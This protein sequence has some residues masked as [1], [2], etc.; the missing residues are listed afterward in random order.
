P[1]VKLSATPLAGGTVQIVNWPGRYGREKLINSA[2]RKRR[3]DGTFDLTW[4]QGSVNVS[5]TMRIISTSQPSGGGGDQP[6]QQSLRGLQLPSSVAD[7]SAGAAQ[8]A[9]QTTG[10]G[11]PAAAPAVAAAN[12]T[13]AQ[14]AQ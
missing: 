2:Q 14:G 7:A 1:G 6:Q 11:T 13:H 5:V 8:N 3:P 10:T 12:A 9:T 4:A